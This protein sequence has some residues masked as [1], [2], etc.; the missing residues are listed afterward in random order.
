MFFFIAEF[1]RA[2]K[3]RKITV[4]GFLISLL[5]SYNG[6]KKIPGEDSCRSKSGQKLCRYQ[7]KSIKF[8]TSCAGHVDVMKK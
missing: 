3:I 5:V 7:S 4:Y 2:T 8:V 1:E 6:L